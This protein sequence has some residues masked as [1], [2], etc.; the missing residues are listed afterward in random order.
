MNEFFQVVIFHRF[1][2]QFQTIARTHLQDLGMFVPANKLLSPNEMDTLLC[3]M[4]IAF[5]SSET[6]RSAPPSPSRRLFMSTCPPPCFALLNRLSLSSSLGGRWHHSVKLNHKSYWAEETVRL[7]MNGWL[8]SVMWVSADEWSG[9][10]GWQPS[11]Q[12][13][14]R[15]LL[16]CYFSI[17]CKISE[18]PRIASGFCTRLDK[19]QASFLLN[20]PTH[21]LTFKCFNAGYFPQ[22]YLPLFTPALL[23]SCFLHLPFCQPVSPHISV[24]WLPLIKHSCRTLRKAPLLFRIVI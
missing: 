9:F 7:R 5:L 4:W 22:S 12:P 11:P 14:G 13:S 8:G 16:R 6:E 3:S 21:F 20:P 10:R 18:I 23:G 17:E 19:I 15:P 24:G 2:N 1:Q